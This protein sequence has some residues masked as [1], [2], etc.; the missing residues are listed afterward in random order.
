MFDTQKR[1]GEGQ[2]LGG[3]L[4]TCINQLRV[5]GEVVVQRGVYGRNPSR[6]VQFKKGWY[7]ISLRFEVSGIDVT[8]VYPDGTSLKL[9]GDNLYCSETIISKVDKTKNM[10]PLG[11]ID[12]SKW[13]GKQGKF[14]IG[15]N[16]DVWVGYGAK[17]MNIDGYTT[18]ETPYNDDMFSTS[19]D[20]N[21]ARDYIIPGFRIHNLKLNENALTI[22][23]W[24]KSDENK[25]SLFGKKGY[26]AFGK[27]YKTVSCDL[28][29]GT[30]YANPGRLRSKKMNNNQWN[31][32]VMTAS[33][34]EIKLYL[35]ESLVSVSPGSTQIKTDALD[36]LLNTHAYVRKVIIYNRVID[37]SE[38]KLINDRM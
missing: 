36:F 2:S 17:K 23:I 35:N 10:L 8:V 19:V 9:N 26:N 4:E 18:I 15:T 25:G 29:N 14:D 1:N 34:S 11:I 13:D 12:F 27:G 5:S 31:Y 21:V 22:A 30:L 7:P 37:E 24:F 6:K 32:V 3:R 16:F 38:V 20:V 33:E 28:N